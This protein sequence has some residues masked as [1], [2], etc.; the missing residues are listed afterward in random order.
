MPK[1][2]LSGKKT[3]KFCTLA[4]DKLRNSTLAHSLKHKNIARSRHCSIG[5]S[6][7][8]P[9]NPSQAKDTIEYKVKDSGD[10][11]KNFEDSFK[12]AHRVH[13]PFK[14]SSPVTQDIL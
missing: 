3:T 11:Y 14:S 10:Q 9:P 2:D 6:H 13:I 5:H 4:E 8:D 7:F 12:A 1:K